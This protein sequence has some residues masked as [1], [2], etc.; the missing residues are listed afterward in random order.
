MSGNTFVSDPDQPSFLQTRDP[1][2]WGW[3]QRIRFVA[4][5]RKQLFNEVLEE[6]SN[7]VEPNVIN[8]YLRL[9]PVPST[10]DQATLTILNDTTVVANAPK[11]SATFKNKISGRVVHQYSFSRVFGPDTTQKEIFDDCVAYQVKD[12]ILGSNCL[13][14]A[15]GTT[16]AGKTFTIQGNGSSPGVI[17]RALDMLFKTIR[18]QVAGVGKY[19]PDK[20]EGILQLDS[21]TISQELDYK[22]RIL[23]WNWDKPLEPIKSGTNNS[24][25]NV[26]SS[27]ESDFISNTFREMQ[28]T[29]CNDSPVDMCNEGGVVYGVWVSF[30]EVYNENI[31]DLLDPMMSR[32]RKRMPLKMAQDGEGI[33]FIRD[34]KMIHVSSGDEAFHVMLYGKANLQVAATNMNSHSSRSHCIFTIRLVRYANS[35]D[36]SYAIVSSFT[37]CDLAG[38]E[39]AKKTLNAGD[40]LK[41]SN[42]I[43]TSLHVLGRCLATIRE[44]QKKK[45]R[46]PVPFRDSKLTRIFQRALTGHERITMIVNANTSSVLF[47]E[48]VNVLKFSAI[49]KQIVLETPIKKSKPPTKKSRFSIMVSRPNPHGTICWDAPPEDDSTSSAG[50]SSDTCIQKYNAQN[51][52]LIMLVE[53]LKEQLSEER[54]KNLTLERSVR[55]KVTET[56]SKIISDM[57]NSWKARVRDMEERNES[58]SAWRL[59]QLENYYKQC[60]E[61]A[62]KRPRESD[63]DDSIV[64]CV[65]PTADKRVKELEEEVQLLEDKCSAVQQLL[66]E[67]QGVQ[68][69]LL[70]ENSSL[71]FQIS[72]KDVEIDKYQRQLLVSHPSCNFFWNVNVC[73]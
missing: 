54:E 61:G 52:E 66:K 26:S 57:E 4:P 58:L 39:R 21:N 12:F 64:E 40:R 7:A 49:A 19:K 53:R 5:V 38:A 9:K 41:E 25:Y 13:L 70:S 16:N 48:T 15:Y 1:S 17:P 59:T 50:L 65:S 2:I 11:N 18:G 24:S 30:A 10:A 47:D 8:T 45:E 6:E 34:L 43:N 20:V 29:L 73:C 63:A 72:S 32:N 36:P 69:Q 31:Y 51:E 3:D 22:N 71:K 46:K 27:S 14:F 33:T 60:L 68:D 37:F 35:D 62:R 55:Q 67:A 23:H 42:N 28:K 56:F 44:N